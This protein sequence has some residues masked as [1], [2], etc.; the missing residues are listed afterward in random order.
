MSLVRDNK[1]VASFY[2]EDQHEN[3]R[4]VIRRYANELQHLKRTGINIP[5]SPW[6]ERT[7]LVCYS[8]RNG[9]LSGAI[10]T[11]RV[12]ML[13]SHTLVTSYETQSI[14]VPIV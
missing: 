13:H 14:G 5:D 12:Q 4:N 11:F 10:K 1:S 3:D 2:I 6:T 7:V 9:A 8:S